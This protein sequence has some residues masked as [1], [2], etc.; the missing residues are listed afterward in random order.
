MGTMTLTEMES[1]LGFLL[2][3][4]ND[5][6]ATDPTRKRRWVNQAYTYMCHPSV[7]PFREMQSI[8]E[9]TLVTGTN[10]YSL[11][12]LDSNTLVA[13]RF[14][15]YVQASTFTNTS[16]KRK[17]RPRPIRHFEQITLST[18]PPVQYAV[19]G[20]TLFINAVPRTNENGHLLRVGYYQEP[21]QLT[22]DSDTTV[23]PTYY[24]RALL[25]LTQ[26]FAETDLGDRELSM[27]TIREATQLLNNAKAEE[28][29]EAEDSGFQVEITLQPVMGI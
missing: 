15:S 28:Q 23:L 8:S 3:N 17:V 5:V 13:I 16:T 1:E 9:V 18:G 7:H 2:R 26:A 10:E 6:D 19:D 24:D 20:S 12:T 4:R 25:K 11:T 29:M 21:D 14:V 27:L 22:A